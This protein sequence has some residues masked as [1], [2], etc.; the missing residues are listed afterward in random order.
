MVGAALAHVKTVALSAEQDEPVELWRE[1]AHVAQ[2]GVEWDVQGHSIDWKAVVLS[3]HPVHVG[4]EC[5]AAQEE[6]QKH[7]ATVHFVQ[8]AVLQTHLQGDGVDGRGQKEEKYSNRGTW[9]K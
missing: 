7:H 1:D 3:I 6:T 8:P 4:K 2:V 9:G 5:N